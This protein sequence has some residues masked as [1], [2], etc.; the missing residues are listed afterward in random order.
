MNKPNK[1]KSP[2]LIYNKFRN[3]NFP[4]DSE[5]LIN[6]EP[7]E[8][9][10]KKS[11]ADLFEIN[12]VD[13]FIKIKIDEIHKTLA[14]FTFSSTNEDKENFIDYYVFNW[15]SKIDALL[16]DNNSDLSKEIKAERIKY[17]TD[18]DNPPNFKN[19]AIKLGLSG[20]SI[21]QYVKNQTMLYEKE[22]RYKIEEEA[23]LLGTA[24]QQLLPEIFEDKRA[25]PNSFL[26]GALFGMVRKVVVN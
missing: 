13:K 15:L 14:D 1:N 8:E 25:I 21:E 10:L 26:R 22:K 24:M 12:D 6:E 18:F 17:A 4:S 9:D 3:I 23:K 11:L 19:E 16:D 20:K 2:K 7:T 5:L